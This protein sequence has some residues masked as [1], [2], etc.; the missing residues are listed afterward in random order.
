MVKKT[1][2]PKRK[3]KS[4]VTSKSP[5]KKR[6]SPRKSPINTRRYNLRSASPKRYSSPKRK[7]AIEKQIASI[8]HT[9]YYIDF[10]EHQKKV[11]KDFKDTVEMYVEDT[12]GENLFLMNETFESLKYTPSNLKAALEELEMC[13][14]E[15]RSA[16]VKEILSTIWIYE[17]IELVIEYGGIKY[18]CTNI[19][20]IGGQGIILSAKGSNGGEFI[21]K[22]LAYDEKDLKEELQKLSKFKAIKG[23]VQPLTPMITFET[24]KT[25]VHACVFPKFGPTLSHL[26][27]YEEFDFNSEFLKWATQQV[28]KILKKIHEK[29]F[30]HLDVHPSNILLGPYNHTEKS[31]EAKL[32]LI[33]FGISTEEKSEVVGDIG[34]VK[35]SSPFIGER[36]ATSKDDLISLIFSMHYLRHGNLPWIEETDFYEASILKK[37]Y[38][39]EKIYEEE[40]YLQLF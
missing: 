23:V 34:V 28:V 40:A 5:K 11:W 2:S 20:A 15:G 37:K 19:M 1:P 22:M 13:T 8:E 26:I 29:G 4:V 35:Y 3:R 7:T 27:K 32:Y 39:D 21:V 30:V 9:N 12:S 14:E 18:S 36:P 17:H 10:D 33:D 38:L 31:Y 24:D 16:L 25:K 6:I